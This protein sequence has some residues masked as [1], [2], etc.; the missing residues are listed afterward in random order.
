MPELSVSPFLLIRSPA[1]SYKSF[2]NIFLKN[3]LKTDFFRAA[4]FMASQTF[5][6]ELK[7]KAF[8]YEDLTSNAKVTLWKYLNRMCF[9]PLPYGFFSSFSTVDWAS[10]Q[11][12]RMVITQHSIIVHPDFKILIEQVNNLKLESLK[13]IKYYVNDSLYQTGK[14]LRFIKQDYTS[15]NKYVIMQMDALPQLN[16]LIHFI[17]PGRTRDEILKFMLKEFG[18]EAPTYSY[19]ESFENE[20]LIVSELLPNIT[21]I[22]YN[23][24]IDQVLYNPSA[25][26]TE[27]LASIS[28]IIKDQRQHLPALIAHLD[29]MLLQ[30]INATYSLYETTISGALNNQ[31]MSKLVPL[32]KNMDKLSAD[33][34]TDVLSV[35]KADFIRK[36]DKQEVSLMVALDPEFGIGYENLAETFDLQNNDMINGLR[37]NAETKRNLQWGPVERMIFKKWNSLHDD[38][39]KKIIITQHDVDLLPESK[40]VLPPGMS[41]LFKEIDGT[42]WIDNIGGGSG[43]ELSARFGISSNTIDENLKKICQQEIAVNNEFI[44]AE[45]AFSPN[46]K[47]SNINQRGQFY[48]YEIPILTYS[49]LKEP[50]KIDLSDLMVAVIDDKVF[51]R[52]AKLNKYIIPRL[53]SAYNYQISPLSIFRFLCDLQFQGVKSNLSFSLP[54]LFPDLSYYPRVQLEETVISPATWILSESQIK[55]LENGNLEEIINI[56]DHFSLQEADNFLVFDKNNKDDL[57][58]FRLLIK[59]KKTA[60]L[61]EYIYPKNPNLKNAEGLPFVSQAI[62]CVINQTKSYTLPSIPYKNIKKNGIQVKRIFSIGEEWLYLKVFS[63]YS[64]TNDILLQMIIPVVK[65]YKKNIPG[66]KWFFI[67]YNDPGYHLRLRF[68]LPDKSVY[69]LL[70]NLQNKL[71]PWLKSGNISYIQIDEYQRELE[72]YPPNIITEIESLFYSNT[73]FIMAASATQEITVNFQLSFAVNTTITFLHFFLEDN[74]QFSDFINQILNNISSEFNSNKEAVRKMDLHYRGFKTELI[75]NDINSIIQKSKKTYNTY[76]QHQH[77]LKAK[78][79]SWDKPSRFNLIMNIIH[80]HINR[81]FENNQ[82]EY[83]YLTYHFIKKHDIYLSHIKNG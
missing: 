36:Y 17:Y 12:A 64:I 62:A 21:G 49:T 54:N 4:I 30:G 59:N 5:Y 77:D 50:Y 14:I 15:A 40:H 10:N 42:L 66:F 7:K 3:A 22:R 58:I 9:R 38:G 43:I 16:N 63:H 37:I 25:I 13:Q 73:E 61:I 83:E 68:Y 51:L 70:A 44:F 45:I 75:L 55:K 46:Q 2:N 29:Q 26:N 27:M 56:S 67:R 52:S 11:S 19:F 80:M 60:T 72:K 41:I 39:I 53:S 81:I 32:V 33:R 48:T 78:I 76:L 31:I 1:Y 20:Q 8:N 57:S 28:I 24:R 82:R 71:S 79:T 34:E 69:E 35:F 23:K 6:T 74:N 65:K 47:T 18:D